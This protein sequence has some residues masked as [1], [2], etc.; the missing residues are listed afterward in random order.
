MIWG[1][2]API[3]GARYYV[4]ADHPRITTQTKPLSPSRSYRLDWERRPGVGIAQGSD[5]CGEDRP[6]I[7]GTKSDSGQDMR[8]LRA[9]ADSESRPASPKPSP[10]SVRT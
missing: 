9:R 7:A 5:G 10:C 2:K 4:G 6:A 1:W 3:P 8:Q